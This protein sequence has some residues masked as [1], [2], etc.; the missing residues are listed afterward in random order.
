MANQIRFVFFFK[1]V[2]QTKKMKNSSMDFPRGGA[3][4][5]TPLEKRTVTDQA[6]L[7]VPM[8]ES[9]FQETLEPSKMKKRNASEVTG[10]KQPKKFKASSESA[11]VLSFKVT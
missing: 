11:T 6:H 7:D 3:S 10:H 2:T 9:L 1:T 8:A 4:T 5:L